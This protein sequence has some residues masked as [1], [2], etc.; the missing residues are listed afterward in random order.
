[1]CRL[2]AIRLFALTLLASVPAAAQTPPECQALMA[3][4]EKQFTLPSHAF[5]VSSGLG[6]TPMQSEVI[7]INGVSYV[8]VHDRW[9]RSPQSSAQ[10][11]QQGRDRLKGS[12]CK[13]L[14]DET[15]GTT[16]A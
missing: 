7:N 12:T 4:G 8:K 11:A 3:A 1:M 15:V 10:L 2:T 6:P 13:Q 5:I 16:P 9:I 14:A